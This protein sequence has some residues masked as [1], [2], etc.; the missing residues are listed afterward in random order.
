MIAYGFYDYFSWIP[1]GS[2]WLYEHMNDLGLPVDFYKHLGGHD[3][4]S[5]IVENSMLPFFGEALD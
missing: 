4:N 1:E 2:Q 5:N 3:F